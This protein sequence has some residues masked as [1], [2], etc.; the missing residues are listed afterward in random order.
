MQKFKQI[1]LSKLLFYIS[2]LSSSCHRI[3]YFELVKHQSNIS[4]ID[5]EHDSVALIA[6]G[7]GRLDDNRGRLLVNFRLMSTC[8]RQMDL[9]VEVSDA[10]CIVCGRRA[11]RSDY[12][13]AFLLP[14]NCYGLLRL[15]SSAYF[16]RHVPL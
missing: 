2:S 3:K 1:A 7:A 4:L 13:C 12:I 14:E 8:R 16:A 6:F 5:L 11:Y 10:F 9:P 15:I